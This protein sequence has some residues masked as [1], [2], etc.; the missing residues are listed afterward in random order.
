MSREPAPPVRRYTDEEV[1]RIL[2][3]ATRLQRSQLSARDPEGLSLA[4][5]EEIA[6]E[7]GIEPASLRRA[8][9]ELESSEAAGPW[10]GVAGAPTTLVVQ[11][12]VPAELASE[13]FEELVPVMRQGALGQGSA[14]AVGR[15]LTWTARSDSNTSSQQITVAVSSDRTGI[16]IEE[17]LGGLAGALRGGIVG[18]VGGAAVGGGI[19]LAAAAGSPLLAVAAPVLLLPGA[20]LLARTI[21]GAQVRSRRQAAES[22]ADRLAA[23]VAGLADQAESAESGAPERRSIPPDLGSR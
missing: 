16:R 8:A 7:A 10:A 18:G 6:R 3:R 1:A 23:L 5:L 2:R 21:F 9:A 12:E 17:R 13:R 15:T 11:R 22:L 4:E 20:W 14:S 19:A